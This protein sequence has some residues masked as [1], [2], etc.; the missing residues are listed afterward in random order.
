MWIQGESEPNRTQSESTVPD[1]RERPY[2][3]P[4]RNAHVP[5]R[6]PQ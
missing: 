2:P 4:Q 1:G 3:D 5:I 6:F